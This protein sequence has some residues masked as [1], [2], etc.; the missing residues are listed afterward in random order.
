MLSGENLEK[1]WNRVVVQSFF[2]LMNS[3]NKKEDKD[4]RKRAKKWIDINNK[5]F[6]LICSYADRNPYSLLDA[7]K[8]ILSGNYNFK[9]KLFRF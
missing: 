4:N 2:D 6:I 7:K 3:G 9:K 1:F 5:E 8:K